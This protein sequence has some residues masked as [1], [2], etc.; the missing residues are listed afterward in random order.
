MVFEYTVKYNGKRYHAGEDVPMSKEEIAEFLGTTE[1][2]E[3]KPVVNASLEEAK[4]VFVEKAK[5][6][7][8]KSKGGRKPKAQR[9]LYD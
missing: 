4:E 3:E 2:K 6:T 8:K 5:E 7:E 9:W 1:V